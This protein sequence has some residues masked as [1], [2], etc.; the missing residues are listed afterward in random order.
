MM[1]PLLRVCPPGGE[2]LKHFVLVFPWMWGP[3]SGE[4]SHKK[5]GFGVHP[6]L[7]ISPNQ[8]SCKSY[9]GRTYDAKLTMWAKTNN[10]GGSNLKNFFWQYL[11]GLQPGPPH[12]I[13]FSI[14]SF[15]IM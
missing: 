12:I 2:G 4:Y 9:D 1:P 7:D 8:A 10:V 5:L 6:P 11:R 15:I 14:V 3:P 13:S